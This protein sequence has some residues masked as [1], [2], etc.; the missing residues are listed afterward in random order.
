MCIEPTGV[1]TAVIALGFFMALGGKATHAQYAAPGDGLPAV[2]AR[3][4]A[5]S[6][7]VLDREG[8]L[9]FSERSAYRVRRVD[10]RTG[11]ITTIAGNGERG[12][13]GDGGPA[14]AAKLNQLGGLAIDSAGDL[15]IGD[16]W[17]HRIRK[18]D[19]PS[20]IITTAVGNGTAGFAGDGGPAT[21]AS[22]NGP[23]DIAFDAQSNLYFTDTENHRIRRVDA[24]TQ[25]IST[26]AGDGRW[27]FDG[28]GGPAR[29]AS[30]SRPHCVMI[31]RSGDIIV[32]DSFDF[33]IRR[34]D[35][36]TGLVSTIAGN[37]YYGSG[38]D[39]GQA[40]DAS[41]TWVGD[42]KFDRDG[43][44]FFTDIANH[45]VRK[46][47]LRT[48]TITAVAGTGRRGFAGDGGPAALGSFDLPDGLVIDTAGN[49][50]ITDH[51]NGRVRRIDARTGLLS[52]IAGSAATPDTPDWSF[53][54]TYDRTVA[55]SL[56]NVPVVL[57]HPDAQRAAAQTII[58]ARAGTSPGV[59]RTFTPPGIPLG[60]RL[61]AVL[62]VHA[63]SN[64]EVR[65]ANGAGLISWA[66]LIAANGLTAI[67]PDHRL[68]SAPRSAHLA[69][70]DL[71]EVISA[72][73]ARAS[74]LNVDTTR[75]CVLTFADGVAL[76]ADILASGVLSPKCVVSFYPRLDVAHQRVFSWGTE[77]ADVR[78]SFS[79]IRRAESGASIP[80]W[81]IAVP[82][83]APTEVA[84]P[85]DRL[86]NI[87]QARN[88]ELTIVAH[89]TGPQGFDRL[90]PDDETQR[91]L[92]R[93]V[94]FMVRIRGP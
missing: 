44:L 88:L 45:R 64:Q 43:N 42:F 24:R 17:N 7:I 28:D 78:R 2:Q 81:F 60:T 93:A 71:R 40:T 21:Q 26:V 68:G 55:E 29:A 79:I 94:E 50:L 8:N 22:I 54:V 62:L 51:W 74:Q 6:G 72:V 91:I 10:A 61:P 77:S 65:P 82:A 41:I 23:F 85:L 48:G 31:A 38:G 58:Y 3:L 59:A 92:Q 16:L 32:C 15:Y 66:R 80:P 56:A 89:A 9:F 14:R 53:H 70:A 34:I 18:V 13:S 27:G 35:A 19:L 37:G 63:W 30:F 76:L 36:T 69:A 5:P 90:T 83:N 4:F 86:R 73:R 49:L 20:G 52:T 87:D 1:R 67:L 25:V 11:T 75:V 84:E 39:G 57:R 46:I 12:Y 47:D 33:R